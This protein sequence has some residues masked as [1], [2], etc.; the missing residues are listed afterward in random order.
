MNFKDLE[1]SRR[2]IKTV[3]FFPSLMVGENETSIKLEGQDPFEFVVELMMDYDVPFGV[4]FSKD[5]RV[6]IIIRFDD[7]IEAFAKDL[8]DME[9]GELSEIIAI[10][11][12]DYVILVEE[13]EDDTV[14]ILSNRFIRTEGEEE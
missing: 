4:L 14:A 10:S 9:Y 7:E 8:K 11:E 12:V 13:L 1:F 3:K 6:N 5:K 2:I